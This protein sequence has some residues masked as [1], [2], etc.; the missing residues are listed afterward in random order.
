MMI[1]SPS[2]P[3]WLHHICLVTVLLWCQGLLAQEPLA[4]KDL[5]SQMTQ[6]VDHSA[7]AGK[8]MDQWSPQREALMNQI[9]ELTLK[10]EWTQFQIQRHRAWIQTE[11]REAQSLALRLEESKRVKRALDPLLEVLYAQ[12]ETAVRQDLPLL[13][14]ERQRRLDFLR[15]EMDRPHAGLG[16]RLG[17]LLEV[18]EI[19][20]AQG[21]RL[22]SRPV[23][24]RVDGVKTAMTQFSLGRLA[25]FRLGRDKALVQKFDPKTNQ[26]ITLPP[27]WGD[28]L[29]RAIA[30]G[31]KKQVAALVELPIGPFPPK[32]DPND[33]S[34][35]IQGGGEHP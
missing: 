31:E 30:M 6:S 16:H 21:R 32:A 35:P 25:L 9:R 8:K 12:L 4:P 26:W 15:Q 17:R 23:M 18:L 27:K 3:R 33:D 2:R 11:T 10:N 24:A 14:E 1:S 28:D 20:A 13:K 5:F 7:R 29:A 22:E 19:E 34:N